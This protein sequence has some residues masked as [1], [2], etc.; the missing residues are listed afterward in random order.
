MGSDIE[1][2]PCTY[3]VWAG[4]LETPPEYCDEDR[5]PDSEYCKPHGEKVAR[6]EALADA[7][8]EDEDGDQ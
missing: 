2:E 5:E 6:M 1:T 7:T 3:E 4:T 8:I